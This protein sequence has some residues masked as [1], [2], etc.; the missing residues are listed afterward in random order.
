LRSKNRVSRSWQKAQIKDRVFAPPAPSSSSDIPYI[1]E[2]SGPPDPE[3]G[4]SGSESDSDPEE[5]SKDEEGSEEEAGSEDK[6]EPPLKKRK[7]KPSSQFPVFP[8][9]NMNELR[10]FM[11][12]L[13]NSSYFNSMVIKIF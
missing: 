2:I 13:K 7:V 11:K 10:N 8:I 6:E 9:R 1:P 12:L 4:D 3:E 5:G